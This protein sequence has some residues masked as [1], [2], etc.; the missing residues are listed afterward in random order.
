M[1]GVARGHIGDG[2]KADSR[3]GFYE[4]IQK[5]V[6]KCLRAFVACRRFL[7]VAKVG[8]GGNGV[9]GC[10]KIDGLLGARTLFGAG[11]NKEVGNEFTFQ[12][13]E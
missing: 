10:C 4:F 6:F 8:V 3:E 1:R 13:T 12:H 7:D 5:A 9:D 2:L 11:G